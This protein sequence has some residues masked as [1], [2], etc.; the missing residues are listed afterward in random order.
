MIGSI[1]NGIRISSAISD[2]TAVTNGSTTTIYTCPANSYAEVQVALNW[3]SNFS[4][5]ANLRIDGDVV[6]HFDDN[7][8]TNLSLFPVVQMLAGSL[9]HPDILRLVIGPSSILSIANS[10][11]STVTCYVTGVCFISGI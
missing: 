10:G 3:E 1:T 6:M 4:G 5:S 7:T 9:T 11:G 2:Q 8:G